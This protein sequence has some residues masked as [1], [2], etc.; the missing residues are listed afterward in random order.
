VSK[1]ESKLERMYERLQPRERARLAVEAMAR[2][3]GLDLKKIVK[4]CPRKEY[5]M[6]D[7]AYSDSVQASRIAVYVT[8]I[9][10][11]RWLARLDMCAVWRDHVIW[12][13]GRM[14]D[15][16]VEDYY[17]GYEAGAEMA[18]AAAGR[19]GKPP[20]HDSDPDAIHQCLTETAVKAQDVIGRIEED[21]AAECKAMLDG[22]DLALREELRLDAPTALRAWAEPILGDLERHREA[23][24][25][26]KVDPEEVQVYADA[27]RKLWGREDLGREE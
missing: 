24:D 4:T 18:W 10:L 1:N 5:T 7:A 3:D 23:L 27:L 25:A 2:G 16:A 15:A 12:T 11:E 20:V 9:D 6:T 17:R 13:L 19:R 14:A 22:L 8:A 26:A 21:L